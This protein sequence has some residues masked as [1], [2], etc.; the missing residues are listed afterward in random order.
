M[1]INITPRPDIR[2]KR[3]RLDHTYWI[4]VLALLIYALVLGLFPKIIG[5]TEII[6]KNPQKTFQT[7]LL[8]PYYGE[9]SDFSKKKR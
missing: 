8:P 4:L 5:G 6:L 7:T 9:K 2:R 1:N 3:P